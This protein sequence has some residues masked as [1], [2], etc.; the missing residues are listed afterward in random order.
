[1]K[2]NRVEKT[3]MNNPIRALVQ[4]F[5]EA[6]MLERLGG[7]V[8]GECVLEIGCGRG[9]GTEIIFDRFGAGRVD[10]FDL[11]PDMIK[12]ARNRLA[13]VPARAVEVICQ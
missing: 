13:H 5:H 2:L 10:A 6:S 9:V 12:S 7:R 4:R 3:L 1:M 11:D 8:E